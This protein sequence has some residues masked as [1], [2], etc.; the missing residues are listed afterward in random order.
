MNQSEV[1]SVF[2]DES[3]LGGQRSGQEDSTYRLCDGRGSRGKLELAETCERDNRRRRLE[4]TIRAYLRQKLW[5]QSQI[6]NPIRKISARAM[7]RTLLARLA[8]GC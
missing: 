7:R 6:S 8:A 4:W 2:E 5:E 3:D 1:F